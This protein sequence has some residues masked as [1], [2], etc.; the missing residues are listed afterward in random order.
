MGLHLQTT[1]RVMLHHP[2][3]FCC[4]ITSSTSV[5]DMLGFHAMQLRDCRDACLIVD[6]ISHICNRCPKGSSCQNDEYSTSTSTGIPKTKC[7]PPFEPLWLSS[8]GEGWRGLPSRKPLCGD[9]AL[10]GIC[11]GNL[12]VLDFSFCYYKHSNHNAPLQPQPWDFQ[13]S[14]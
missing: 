14:W 12:Q 11:C 4:L 7:L 5:A 10:E 2:L 6:V 3:F 8:W 13:L 9:P 1:K